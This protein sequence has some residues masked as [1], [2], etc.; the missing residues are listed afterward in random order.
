VLVRQFRPAVRKVVTEIPAGVLD[1][2]GEDAIETHCCDL[3]QGGCGSFFALLVHV[4]MTIQTSRF[5]FKATHIPIVT[6]NTTDEPLS[7]D[8]PLFY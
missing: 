7:A 1:V 3:D 6:W 4:T 2:P 5:D 8:N